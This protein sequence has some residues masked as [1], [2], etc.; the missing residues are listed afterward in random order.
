MRKNEYKIVQKE[1][2]EMSR[3]AIR[4]IVVIVSVACIVAMLAL[5]V[6]QFLPYWNYTNR[7]EEALT[8]S[9]QKFTWFPYKDAPLEK[10]LKAADENY[11]INLFAIMPFVLLIATVVSLVL[12]II[13]PKGFLAGL[14]YI[15][16]GAAAVWGYTSFKV[17]S[18]GT[19]YQLQLTLSYV[20]LAL[21]VIRLILWILGTERK[22]EYITA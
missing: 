13:Q 20:I 22:Q 15:I 14:I 7:S 17:Y 2:S 3:S 11:N 8:S 6:M 10:A 12:T 18:I 21:A 16:A 1:G 9:I 4:N 19:T 5:L